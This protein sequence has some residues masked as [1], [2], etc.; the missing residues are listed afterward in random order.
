VR[1]AWRVAV[2]AAGAIGAAALSLGLAPSASAHPLGNFT[3][4]TYS[5]V[6]VEPTAVSV[7]VVVDSAEVPT[8]QALPQAREGLSPGESAAYQQ[9][10]C[11]DVVVGTQVALDGTEV[12][13]ALVRSGLEL[14]TGTAGLPTTRLTCEL[15]GDAR[16]V[17]AALTFASTVAQDR[18]GW[19]EITIVG[20]GVTLA[21]ATVGTESVSAALTA[22]PR[23]LLTSPLDQRSATARVRAVTG[24]VGGQSAIPGAPAGS[25]TRGVDRLTSAYTDLVAANDL[26]VGFGVVAVLLAMLLGAAHAFAPG[27]G[28]ALMAASLV[29]RHGSFRSAAIIGLSVTVTHSAGVLLLG[30]VVTVTSFAAPERVYPWLGLVSGVLLVGIGLALLR[31]ALR[32]PRGV[33]VAASATSGEVAVHEHLHPPALAHAHGAVD[34][35]PHTHTHTHDDVGAHPH[36]DDVAHSHQH[37]HTHPHADGVPHSHGLVTHTH[38]V[39]A[40]L[41]ARSMMAVGFTG[42]LVPSPS[43]LLVLLG[44]I[45]LGRAW[46]GVVLVLAYGVGMAVALVGTGLLLVRARDWL[47]ARSDWLA[48]RGRGRVIIAAGRALPAITA[49]VVV[50]IGVG[51]AVRGAAAI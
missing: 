48:A 14:P 40:G 28:K 42:G 51:V 3:I 38:Q 20:D 34:A 1:R 2:S 31:A 7:D 9:R 22:Y 45:A 37:A 5:A 11:A 26:T 29:G 50:V 47:E 16:T 18:V 30:V 27:H 32:T 13:L 43:A 24:D 36:P 35:R 33:P 23:D 39:P 10:A 41:N 17:G 8:L 21:D 44:G 19:R 25:V 12:P 15:R 4:N 6:R 46:F 49:V